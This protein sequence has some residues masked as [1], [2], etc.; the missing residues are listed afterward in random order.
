MNQNNVLYIDLER[1]CFHVRNRSDLFNEWLGGVGVAL[2]LYKE[3]AVRGA[4]PFDPGNVIVFAIGPLTAFYPLAS[5]VVAVFKSP[6]TGNYGESHA[7]GRSATAIR[8]AG[9]EA[10]VIKGVSDRPIYLVISEKGVQ[11]RDAATL[12]GMRSTYTVGRVLREA[13]LGAGVRTIMRIGRAGEKLV[14]YACV[15]TETYRHFGRMGL[16]AV[17]GSKKLKA[18]IIYGKSSIRAPK[19][20][21]YRDA[22]DEIYGLA[23]KSDSMKKYHELGTALNV[24]PLNA[25]GALPTKNLTSNKFEE[26]ERISGESLASNKLGRRVACSH[27]P[28]ACIHLA[29]IREPYPD[30]PYFYKTTFVS[31]DYEPIYSLGSML[32]ISNVDDLLKLMDEV[33]RGGLDAMSTGVALAWATEA[34]KKG[35]VKSNDVLVDIDWGKVDAYRV[36]VEFVLNQPNEFYEALAKGIDYAS[37]VYGGKEFALSFGGNEMPGYHTG[38]AAY[39]GYLIG[40]RHSHLDS[41]GYSLDQK[42]RGLTPD[43]LVDRL[44]KEECWRQTLSSLVVCY[45]SR[46]IYEP[47]VVKKALNA[48]GYESNEEELEALGRRIYEEKQ[49]LKASEGFDPT[50]LRAPERI[51]ETPSLHGFIDRD[52]IRTALEHYSKVFKKIV[53]KT[54]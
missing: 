9:Y 44:I 54:F 45:F 21:V 4:T 11:F 16:G 52:Y 42:T 2:Q 35:F 46:S 26:A 41:A 53:E 25:L 29:T 12:W 47:S 10:I 39:I 33:E 20:K 15:V 7:G 14:R 22:Y 48:L 23:I 40:S 19:I 3:E 51:F 6:L 8:S 17:F 36:A 24:L 1:K 49:A 28:V 18:L 32:G 5:K 34:Y 38:P 27:C 50:S 37:K 43:E 31:Y 13:L 30:E